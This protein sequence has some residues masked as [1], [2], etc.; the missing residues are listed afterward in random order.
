MIELNSKT[1]H[2][3]L[4]VEWVKK[5]LDV[6][7][8]M[9]DAKYSIVSPKFVDDYYEVVYGDE[10][11]WGAHAVS[12]ECYKYVCPTYTVSEL[13][14]KLHEWIHP[15]ID[16]KEYKG[17]LRFIKDAPLYLFYYNLKR[18]GEEKPNEGYIFA[19]YEHPIESLAAVLIQCHEKEIGLVAKDTGDI[20]DKE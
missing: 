3:F 15:T 18:D 6:G 8:D 9:S 5:L 12:P 13:L 2:D 4:D 1:R 14:Y 7:V 19:E 20:S 11:S 10:M 17:G 16:G